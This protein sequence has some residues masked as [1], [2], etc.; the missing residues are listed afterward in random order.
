MD[1]LLA[2]RLRHL[3][4]P[5]RSGLLSQSLRGIEREALRVDRAGQLA[6]TGHPVRLGSALTHPQITTDYSE[7][8][9]EFITPAEP[10]VET[11]LQSLDTIHRH[12]ARELGDGERLW[13][14]SM[15]SALPAEDEIPIARYGSSHIGMLKHVYRRGLALRY[16]R[17]MQ[18][19]AGV[20]YNYSV[21]PGL[22]ALLDE[23]PAAADPRA[24][25]ERQSDGYLALIRNFH[26]YN[27]LLMLLFGASPALSAAFL[28]GREHTLQPLSPDTLYLPHATSLRM[29]DLGYQNDAQSRLRPP[30]N[31]LERYLASLAHAVREPHPAYERLGTHRDGEWVQMNTH[32][33]QIENEYYATIRP[34]RVT[35]RGERPI[36]ALFERGIQY[37]EV[38]CLDID[39]FVP[40]G[41]GADCARVVEVFL[42]WCALQDSPPCNDL[43]L[44]QQQANFAAT[45]REG[46]RPG[47]RLLRG[48]GD[49]ALVDWA[50][51]LVEQMAPVAELL[52]AGTGDGAHAAALQRQQAVL[53]DLDLSPSARVLDA[54]RAAGGSFHGWSLQQ[55]ERHTQALL[56]RS[57]DATQQAGF[58]ELARRSI[59]EQQAIER[60]DVGSF[61]AF[62]Q[63]YNTRIPAA[64]LA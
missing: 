13:S 52:D 53:R 37:V 49:V 17:R 54:V 60:S 46:R 48:D 2:R 6:M 51:A 10:A 9:M 5:S 58:A 26:R 43:S 20:H 23:A 4:D 25:L 8:L 41:I 57:L 3:S 61:D 62:V 11:V 34:K 39:P 7:S 19:I 64:L 14:Q 12:V 29:S 31:S 55:A 21:A 40:L 32:V 35:E 56:A 24:A 47:L 30:C 45:V 44:R 59:E 18:C 16:G 63:A 28:E 42:L 50:Q 33:L 22:W 36:E 27:W 15:P 38:R 1:D